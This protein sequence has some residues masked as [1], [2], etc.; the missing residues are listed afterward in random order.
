ME[1][2]RSRYRSRKGRIL[3]ELNLRV[4]NQLFDSRDPSPF[5]E[6]DLDENAV[7]YIVSSANEHSLASPMTLVIHLSEAGSL[8]V[9]QATIV[10]AIHNHFAYNADQLRRKLKQI[11]RQGQFFLMIGLV[12]LAVCLMI[13][14][15]LNPFSSHNA[16]A[17]LQEGLVIIG[18]VAMWRPIDVFLYSWWPQVSMRRVYEKL[19]RIPVEVK[20]PEKSGSVSEPLPK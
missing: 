16:V 4:I 5:L 11:I 13:S 17:I 9:D 14:E 7:D 3:I 2:S 18:W 10:D 1:K 20:L 19:S 8:S 12:I 6:R 15:S